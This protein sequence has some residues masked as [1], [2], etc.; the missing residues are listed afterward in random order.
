MT[1]KYRIAIS[2]TPTQNSNL[3]RGVGFYTQRL[4]NSLELIIKQNPNYKNFQINLFDQNNFD[5]SKYDLIH[6][7]YFDVF[8]PTLSIFKRPTIVTVH[9]LIPLSFP[10]HYPVGIKG[11]INWLKQKSQLK[12]A[13]YIIT[14]SISSRFEILKHLKYREDHIFPIYLAADSSFGPIDKITAKSLTK[15][16][17]LPNKF[18]LYVGDVNWNKNLDSLALSCIKLDYPL[19]VVGST[20][21]TNHIIP[22]PWT[23]CLQIF[24]DLQSKHPQLILTTGYLPNNE[25][26]AVYNLATIYCQPSYA[27]GF[28]LPL[29]EAMQSGCPVIYSQTSSLPELTNYLGLFFDPYNKLELQKCLKKMWTDQELRQTTKVEGLKKAKIFSWENTAIQTL[30]VYRLALQHHG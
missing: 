19:V 29:L 16:L 9:D 18:V 23:K 14:D 1:N 17:N 26:N 6:Y 15:N 12:K 8:Q 21:A 27:E 11:K 5:V 30:E 25:L 3:Q 28:G 7:P 20:A 13:D 2:V 4:I 24:K 10:K 22:H